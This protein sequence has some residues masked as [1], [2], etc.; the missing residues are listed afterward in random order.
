MGQDI[1]YSPQSASVEWTT[2]RDDFGRQRLRI[3][4]VAPPC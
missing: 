3:H 1:R 4:S 2:Y